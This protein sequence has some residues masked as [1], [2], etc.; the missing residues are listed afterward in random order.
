MNRH[1]SVEPHASADRH[2]RPSKW[3]SSEQQFSRT[4]LNNEPTRG[5][6]A[7]ASH[8]GSI[9]HDGAGNR[10]NGRCPCRAPTPFDQS[11][12]FAWSGAEHGRR[13]GVLPFR[14]KAVTGITP[15]RVTTDG[16]DSYPRAVQTELGE[17]ARHRTNRYLTDVFD[18]TFL[19]W[20][21]YFLLARVTA[22][23]RAGVGMQARHAVRAARRV[24]PRIG[25][26]LS[27]SRSFQDLT[28]LTIT[29]KAT[30]SGG[31][32]HM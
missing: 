4:R 23:P 16:H 30:R 8:S 19:A 12:R 11:R 5:S 7:A 21:C 31:R 17:G 27:R 3:C 32:P 13:H 18:K 9:D 14:S 15:A 6:G 26:L 10:P 25:P 29:R 24:W 1:V 20:S 28:S 2:D 22:W